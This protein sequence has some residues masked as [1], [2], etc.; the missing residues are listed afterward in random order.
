MRVELSPARLR[1]PIWP[2]GIRPRSFEPGDAGSL[3]SL[4]EHGYRRGGGSVAPF[5]PVVDRYDDG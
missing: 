4:L 3:H 5:D 1:E 2:D